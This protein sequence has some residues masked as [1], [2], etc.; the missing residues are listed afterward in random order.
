M[1]L[2]PRRPAQYVVV[3][4]YSDEAINTAIKGT[5]AVYFGSSFYIIYQ[6]PVIHTTN[7]HGTIIQYKYLNRVYFDFKTNLCLIV[8]GREEKYIFTQV[9]FNL[10]GIFNGINE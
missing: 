4:D 7:F 3:T 10:Q 2:F 1:Y 9:S 5:H 6:K 8:P